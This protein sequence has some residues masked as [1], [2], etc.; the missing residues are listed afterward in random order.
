MSEP[1]LDGRAAVVTG[2][3]HGIG[4]ETMLALRDTADGPWPLEALAREI[5]EKPGG[6]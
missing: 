1:V 6:G 5:R 4:R 2:S 3:S